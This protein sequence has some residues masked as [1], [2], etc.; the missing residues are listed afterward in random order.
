MPSLPQ[1]VFKKSRDGILKGILHNNG[2]GNFVVA[3]QCDKISCFSGKNNSIFFHI[4][5]VMSV[6]LDAT[7]SKA[8]SFTEERLS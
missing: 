2:D 3:C 7:S 5:R 6:S 1:H 4:L 8:T